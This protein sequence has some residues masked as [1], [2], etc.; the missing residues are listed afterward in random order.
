MPKL[1]NLERNSKFIGMFVTP[2]YIIDYKTN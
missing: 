1:R 2:D